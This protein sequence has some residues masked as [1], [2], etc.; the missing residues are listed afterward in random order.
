MRTSKTYAGFKVVNGLIFIA[1]G[2]LIIV[3]MGATVGLQFEAVSGY[4]LGGALIA[5]GVYRAVGFVRSVT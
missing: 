3:R 4:V 2:I 5:L 1:L